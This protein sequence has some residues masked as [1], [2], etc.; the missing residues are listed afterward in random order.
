M[1]N[2]IKAG[3][4]KVDGDNQK[5]AAAALV[6]QKIKAKFDEEFGTGETGTVFTDHTHGGTFLRLKGFQL[7][8]MIAAALDP[9]TKTLVGEIINHLYERAIE[10]LI[11]YSI[12]N[13]YT[14]Y[15]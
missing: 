15:R 10:C 8:T 14:S 1:I 4:I 5:S 6:L 11:H 2:Q 3:M 7:K 12:N 9:R 13:R